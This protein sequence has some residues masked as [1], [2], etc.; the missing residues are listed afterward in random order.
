MAKVG[1][2]F[3]SSNG[4]TKKVAQL[5]RDAFGEGAELHDVKR[6]RVGDLEEYDLLV[7]GSPTYEAGE[8]Q[9]HWYAFHRQMR[10]ANLTGKA[11]AVFA[12]GD[13]QKYR[14]TFADALEPLAQRAL[15]CG[16]RLVGEWP[17]AGY[18]FKSSQGIRGENFLG[19]VIDEDRQGELTRERVE[20][21]VDGLKRELERGSRLSARAAGAESS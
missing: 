13:Q 7:L 5:I 14:K 15:E 4:A 12:L 2:F 20:M 18:D 3:G 11:A 6:S 9:K 19:L 1:I 21:W 17:I 16:A 10:R 8:L